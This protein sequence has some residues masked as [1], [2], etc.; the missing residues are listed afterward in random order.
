MVRGGL[1][2]KIPNNSLSELCTDFVFDELTLLLISGDKVNFSAGFRRYFVG[3][4]I[5]EFDLVMPAISPN[6]TIFC[7]Y[8]IHRLHIP[9]IGITKFQLICC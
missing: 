9:T 2:T 4:D 7:S 5:Q 3:A 1:W 8:G 6:H